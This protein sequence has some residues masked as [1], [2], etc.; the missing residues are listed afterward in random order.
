MYQRSQFANRLPSEVLGT[1]CFSNDIASYYFDRGIWFFGTAVTGRL[2]EA[3]NH[4][5]QA[6]A[7]GQREREFARCM[8]DNMLTS[9][10]GFQDPAGI[11]TG[12]KGADQDP[13]D[14]EVGE[15]ILESGY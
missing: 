1:Q 8:G 5:N 4:K 9:A 14:D 6:I 10:A 15:T 13:E 7:N 3:G 12:R 2:Q 11:S